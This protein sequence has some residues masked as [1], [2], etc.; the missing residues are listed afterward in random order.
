MT[1]A[2]LELT[3]L[4]WAPADKGTRAHVFSLN[5]LSLRV[6][7][8][9]FVGL[10]GPNGSGKTSLLR[11]AMRFSKPTGGEVRFSGENLWGKTA[12]WSANHISVLAQEFPAAA[13][14]GVREVVAM[15]RLPYQ[16][17]FL[18]ES[19]ADREVVDAAISTMGIEHLR[20]QLFSSLSGGEKQ[21]VLLARALVQE[22]QL[23][24][25]DEPTNHLDPRHQLDLLA[26]VK[27]SGV[28]VLASLHDLNLAAS[29]CDRL[30]VIKDGRIVAEGT[31]WAVLTS[32][33]LMDVYGTYA[34]VDQHP[35]TG[36]PR[37]TW[38]I[39]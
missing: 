16:G 1:Q 22:P 4:D 3:N 19:L 29:F 2:L 6:E 34:L 8:S 14:L 9:E 28:A 5:K 12:R 21:R 15:G 30:Y 18:G 13:G 36:A 38:K 11:C 23:M 33:L 39:T 27:G 26:L 32:D 10:I 37:I 25:L 24:I 31:P 20:S 7:P 35:F 17:R